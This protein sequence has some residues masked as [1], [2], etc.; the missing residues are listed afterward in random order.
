MK[1]NILLTSGDSSVAV[2]L[3]MTPILSFSRRQY[4]S[5]YRVRY[6]PFSQYEYV[7]GRFIPSPGA[8]S[9]TIENV[10]IP[11]SLNE[12]GDPW[13]TEVTELRKQANNYKVLIKR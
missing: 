5:E 3:K 2:I 10:S 9:P 12:R 11:K 13:Y 7:D 1:L 8:G 6:R 4:R